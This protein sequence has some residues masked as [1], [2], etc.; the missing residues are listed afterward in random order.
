[1]ATEVTQ[2]TVVQWGRVV[3][4]LDIVA[5]CKGFIQAKGEQKRSSKSALLR[6]GATR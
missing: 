4:Q 3:F 6:K 2:A 5:F 1:M